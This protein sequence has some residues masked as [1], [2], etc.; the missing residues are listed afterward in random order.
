MRTA[1]LR[2][3]GWDVHGRS[4]CKSRRERRQGAGKRVSQNVLA[5]RR[6]QVFHSFISNLVNI[7]VVLRNKDVKVAEVRS[8]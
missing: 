8:P 2:P 4:V 6:E 7:A 1:W 3:S 5:R